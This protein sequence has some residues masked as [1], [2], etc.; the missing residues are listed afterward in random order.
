MICKI[1]MIFETAHIYRENIISDRCMLL[2]SSSTIH[3]A[4]FGHWRT[5]VQAKN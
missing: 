3:H 5:H 1:R 4:E 2:S